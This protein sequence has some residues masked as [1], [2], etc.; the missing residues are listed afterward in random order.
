MA[1]VVGNQWELAIYT[2]CKTKFI[3]LHF[4]HFLPFLKVLADKLM[5]H[6]QITFESWLNNVAKT[7]TKTKVYFY[8]VMYNYVTQHA[9]HSLKF[10]GTL[11]KTIV[12]L[13]FE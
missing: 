10:T 7:K 12:K 13:I 5:Q 3:V 11:H 8:T 9:S 6:S 2:G 4:A 1:I